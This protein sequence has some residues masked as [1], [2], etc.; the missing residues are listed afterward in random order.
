MT[1]KTNTLSVYTYPKLQQSYGLPMSFAV[2]ASGGVKDISEEE[3]A[4]LKRMG[5]VIPIKPEQV[6]IGHTDQISAVIDCLD[7]LFASASFDNTVLLW[8]AKTLVSL[9]H[10]LFFEDQIPEVGK[11]QYI[12]VMNSI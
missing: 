6:L 10:F 9:L 8:D 12:F 2:P 7:Y 4:V 1:D 3:L 11:H 5:K